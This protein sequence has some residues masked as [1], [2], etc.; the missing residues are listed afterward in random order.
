MIASRSMTV[1]LY[2]LSIAK[3][4]QKQTAELFATLTADI[5][6]CEPLE[7]IDTDQVGSTTPA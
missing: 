6:E 7:I 2:P 4:R 5:S 3:R 1:P